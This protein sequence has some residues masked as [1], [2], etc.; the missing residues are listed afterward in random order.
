[1]WSMLL[2]SVS[3]SLLDGAVLATSICM[4]IWALLRLVPRDEAARPYYRYF[5]MAV[6]LG[7]ALLIFL[8]LGAEVASFVRASSPPASPVPE[9]FEENPGQRQ[10]QTR[11]SHQRCAEDEGAGDEY[12]VVF[13]AKAH[14]GHQ[15]GE[16]HSGREDVEYLLHPLEFLE[17]VAVTTGGRRHRRRFGVGGRLRA[18]AGN[19]GVM[20]FGGSHNRAI[21][22]LGQV[23]GKIRYL[24]YSNG[25][26]V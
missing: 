17:P 9:S 26:G 2:G 25:G 8:V 13:Q 4:A 20:Q 16:K 12:R 5:R 3:P 6:I 10:H 11:H 14:I 23:G 7:A 24:Q 1:M 18:F 21:L 19:G 22:D 15:R